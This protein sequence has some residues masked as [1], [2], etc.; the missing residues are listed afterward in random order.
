MIGASKKNVNNKFWYIQNCDLNNAAAAA[1]F[2][3]RW[4]S[5]LILVLMQYVQRLCN[6]GA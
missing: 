5:L 4:T 6:D 2:S 1:A 3:K